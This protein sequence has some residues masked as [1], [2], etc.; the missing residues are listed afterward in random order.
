MRGSY[1]RVRWHQPE[2]LPVKEE[3]ARLI[4]AAAPISDDR[5]ALLDMLLLVGIPVVEGAD[6]ASQYAVELLKLAAEVEHALMVQYLYAAAS[7]PDEPGADS[8]N[9]HGKL[10]DV[11]I[12]E[13]GHL[14]TVQN[15]LLL[16]GGRDALYMQRDAMRQI[17]DKNPIPFV[18]EP[19]SKGSLAKYVAAEMPGQVPPELAVKVDE[20]VRLASKSA[21]VDTHR[22][23]VI[24]EL[25]AWIFTPPRE[26]EG[27]VDFAALAP[28]PKEPH[29]RDDDLSDALE[30][31]QHEALPEEWHVFEP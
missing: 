5:N 7:L 27:K 18:L 20:L 21:G 4:R 6:T 1:T 26:S 28:L 2:S 9:Y 25:L 23:G 31:E 22:V 3:S 24:Y 15:L 11:A 30:I 16:V 19:I 10:M 8:V 14:A 12:Q 17:S 29:L 13:M